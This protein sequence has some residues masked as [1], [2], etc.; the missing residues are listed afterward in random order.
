MAIFTVG[1]VLGSHS[2]T[3]AGRALDPLLGDLLL[4]RVV[5][6]RTYRTET[7]NIFRD[8]NDDYGLVIADTVPPVG[9]VRQPPPLPPILPFYQSAN[10][11]RTDWDWR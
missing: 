11:A 2:E 1:A 7:R 10:I 9:A 6:F 4:L 8:V 3:K 5:V